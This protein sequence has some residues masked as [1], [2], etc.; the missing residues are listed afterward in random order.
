MA[1]NLVLK[2]RETQT[3]DEQQ[4]RRDILVILAASMPDDERADM[5]I[6]LLKT[7]PRSK[8]SDKH[9]FKM[10]IDWMPMDD[11]ENMRS[12]PVTEQAKWFHLAIKLDD[13]PDD[14]ESQIEL[15]TRERN[16]VWDR[17]RD[18]GFK[19][20]GALSPQW[21]AFVTHFCQTMGYKFDFEK[22]DEKED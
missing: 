9:W 11:R 19:M 14:Q 6:R 18:P 15:T 20:T 7:F 21:A 13:L 10:L 12:L 1:K 5:M 16:L 2:V 17:L 8:V 22:D 4:L 3:V